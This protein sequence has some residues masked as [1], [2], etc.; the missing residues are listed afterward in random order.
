MGFFFMAEEGK[1]P[2]AFK[3]CGIFQA[4][5]DIGLGV[6]YGMYGDGAGSGERNAGLE[7]G[8]RLP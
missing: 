1:V 5:C 2:W 8:E 4:A 3:M 7:K 6:Q